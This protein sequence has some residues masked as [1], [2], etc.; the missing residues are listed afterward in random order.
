MISN[1]SDDIVWF[2]YKPSFPYWTLAED[3]EKNVGTA[4]L[5]FREGIKQT[6]ASPGLTIEPGAEAALGAAPNI[7]VL[8]RSPGEQ[9]AWQAAS[10]IADSISDKVRDTFT[11]ALEDNSSPAG[12]AVIACVSEAYSIGQAAENGDQSQDVLSQLSTGLGLYNGGRECS[13]K[14]SAAQEAEAEQHV[15][16]TIS[17]NEIQAETHSDDE[18][19]DTDDLYDDALKFFE[20]GLK[21]HA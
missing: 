8:S 7:I 21:V 13:E 4:T 10:L 2:V 11:G 14:I 1:T 15:T 17:L 18:W 16:P 5:L 12:S 20:D 3:I 19:R 6:V 9:A